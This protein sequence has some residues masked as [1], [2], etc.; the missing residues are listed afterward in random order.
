[1]VK[2]LQLFWFAL[3]LDAA[4]ALVLETFRVFKNH[5]DLQ[6]LVAKPQVPNYRS[7]VKELKLSYHNISAHV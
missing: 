1:M 6:L 7:Y 2:N 5:R 4:W 3:L